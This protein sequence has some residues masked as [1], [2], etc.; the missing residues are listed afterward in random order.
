MDSIDLKSMHLLYSGDLFPYVGAETSESQRKEVT[1][2][3]VMP[4]LLPE[5][6]GEPTE[7]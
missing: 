4:E 1:L 6:H 3:A 5:E 7:S 2:I